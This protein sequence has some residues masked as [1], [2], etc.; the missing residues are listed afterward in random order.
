MIYPQCPREK[1]HQLSLVTGVAIHQ[2]I[3]ELGATDAKLKWPNDILVH[4]RKLCGILLECVDIQ[5]KQAVL[6][7]FG[8]NLAAAK[9]AELPSDIEGLYIG[10]TK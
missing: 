3:H 9:D 5:D 8:L 2:T 4:G 1:A 7:G 6:I 10:L